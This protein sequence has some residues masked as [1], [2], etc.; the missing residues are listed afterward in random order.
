MKI[1]RK[2]GA[3]AALVLTLLV[4][5]GLTASFAFGEGSG[6]TV[7]LRADLAGRAG[8]AH[9]I[10]V[11]KLQGRRLRW[12]LAYKRLAGTRPVSARL[13]LRK[14]A[15]ATRL[16]GSCATLARGR[17]RVSAAL[18]RALTHHKTVVELRS[19]RTGAP[20]IAGTVTLQQVPVLVISS[21]KPGERVRLPA[22]IAYAVSEGEVRQG[23]SLQLEVFVADRDGKHVALALPES[24]GTV[25]L[26]DVKD[27]YLVGKHD[28]T[29]RLMSDGV[30]LPNPEATVVVRDLT[31]EGR[32]GG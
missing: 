12:S 22:E 29:F 14:S 2:Q 13:H 1:E 25:T 16:C 23:E 24:S 4:A 17:L 19:A 6:R 15:R 26:P 30:P 21:P 8:P 11:A 28:L 9:G 10:F 27:A 18:A 3:I 7:G 32:K 31:I 5:A 20:A